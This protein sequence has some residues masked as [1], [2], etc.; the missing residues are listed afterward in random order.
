MRHG[1]SSVRKGKE[2][3]LVPLSLWES[4]VDAAFSAPFGARLRLWEVRL[5]STYGSSSSE[6]SL[7]CL[8]MVGAQAACCDDASPN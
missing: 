2:M 1:S 3:P 6:R 7:I 8:G 4:T 5:G